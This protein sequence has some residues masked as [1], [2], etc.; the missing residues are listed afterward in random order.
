MKCKVKKKKKQEEECASLQ[1][2][3][4]VGTA[5]PEQWAQATW[6]SP[7]VASARCTK[8]EEVCEDNDNTLYTSAE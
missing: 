5:V 6:L 2:C 1:E 3:D 8:N 4:P 7:N